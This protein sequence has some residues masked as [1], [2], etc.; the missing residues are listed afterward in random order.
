MR[1]LGHDNKKETSR[2]KLDLFKTQHKTMP[3]GGIK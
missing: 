1:S 3:Y 2:G